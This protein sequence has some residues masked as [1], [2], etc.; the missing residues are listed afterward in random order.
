MA[1]L[2][3]TPTPLPAITRR[4]VNSAI[5]APSSEDQIVKLTRREIEVLTLVVQ[6][7]SSKEV[8]DRL[9]VSKR[10]VDFHLANIYDKLHVSNRVQAFRRATRLGLI[11]Y[12]AQFVD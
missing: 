3:V 2:S 10:T 8:A 12:E 11:P 6:G 1:A 5:I 7:N 9:Y 4:S